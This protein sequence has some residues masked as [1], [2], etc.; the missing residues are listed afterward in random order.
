M[1]M[2]IAILPHAASLGAGTGPPA[3]R[4]SRV[5]VA[6]GVLVDRPRGGRAQLPLYPAAFSR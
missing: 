6:A 1:M 2:L 5:T 4:P 3:C